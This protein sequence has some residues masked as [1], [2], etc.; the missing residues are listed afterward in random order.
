ML[1]PELS[2]VKIFDLE[3]RTTVFGE[4]VIN[5]GK[6][7]SRNV[8][9]LPLIS[10]FIRAGTSVGANYMEADCAESRKDFEHKIGIC[11]KEAKETR[12]WIQMIVCAIPELKQQSKFLWQEA[13]ELQL[14]FVSIVKKSKLNS[15]DIRN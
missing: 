15:S 3:Q 2:K 1:N 8:I 11:K 4:K 5:F 7:V 9:T 13:N 6:M 14:I 12:Y 10:Q